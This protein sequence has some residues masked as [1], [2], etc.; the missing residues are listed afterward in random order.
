MREKI[1]PVNGTLADIGHVAAKLDG[2]AHGAL[3][4][5]GGR[6]VLH[7]IFYVNERKAA[8]IFLEIRERILAGDADPAEVHFHVDEFGMRFGEKKIVGEFAGERIG[9]IEFERVIVIAELDAGLGAGFARFIK[10]FS[11]ALPAVRRRALLFVNPRTNDEAV[12]DDF[13][14]LESFRP[15]FLDDIVADVA[16]RRG[17]AMLVEDRANVLRSMVEVSGALDFLVARGGDFRD[18]ALEVGFHGFAYGVELQAD[19]VNAMRGRRSTG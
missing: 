15:I 18:C 8:R 6:S 12:A 19:A 2:L 5:A 9:G 4:S 13:G 16:G 7:P 17:Q 11:G 14:G 1:F 3:V 10:K